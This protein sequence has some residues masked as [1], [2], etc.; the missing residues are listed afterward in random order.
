MVNPPLAPDGVWTP[1]HQS[2]F[3][4]VKEVWSP[5]LT[6]LVR[7]KRVTGL[8]LKGVC[9][10]GIELPSLEEIREVRIQYCDPFDFASLYRLPNIAILQTRNAKS[11]RPFDLSKLMHLREIDVDWSSTLR[12]VDLTTTIERATIRRWPGKDLAFF[13]GLVGLREL[14]LQF[15]PKLVSTHG[16]EDLG[17]L[18]LLSIF[19][20]KSLVDLEP[21]EKARSIRILRIEACKKAASGLREVCGAQTLEELVFAPGTDIPSMRGLEK[22]TRLQR[23][24]FG[25]S[26]ILD[27]DLTPLIKMPALRE[28]GVRNRKGY[29]PTVDEVAAHLRRM[30]SPGVAG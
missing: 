14:E 24:S 28:F 4:D 15:A 16:I 9:R 11:S 12:G 29:A 30:R 19:S 22:L 1:D 5:E 25:A 20:A 23:V 7:K 26:R 17:L 18:A 8:V 13:R 2:H 3:L 6:E 27:G 21:I 10:V